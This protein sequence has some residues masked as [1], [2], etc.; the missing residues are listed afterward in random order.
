M[1]AREVPAAPVPEARADRAG[2]Q[3]PI[4]RLPAIPPP[5]ASP[6]PSTA[7]HFVLPASGS[8]RLS[9][10]LS[11]WPAAF[12][13]PATLSTLSPLPRA[14]V[15]AQRISGRRRQPTHSTRLAQRSGWPAWSAAVEA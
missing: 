10:V 7:W 15:L 9:Q 2:E 3:A 13:A 4:V 6:Q 11:A 8:A 12:W 1:G 5:E 14:E